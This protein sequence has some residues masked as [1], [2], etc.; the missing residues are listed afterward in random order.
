MNSTAKDSELPAADSCAIMEGED[1]EDDLIFTSKKSLFGKIK[2]FTYKVGAHPLCRCWG[3]QLSPAPQIRGEPLNPLALTVR[4]GRNAA[5]VLMEWQR[6]RWSCGYV[7]LESGLLGSFP[8]LDAGHL[9]ATSTSGPH[10]PNPVCQQ[11]FGGTANV[12]KSPSLPTAFT[13]LTHTPCMPVPRAAVSK[14]LEDR[15]GLVF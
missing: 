4:M 10:F 7:V 11:G 5:G 15:Q 14:E 12:P 2:S 6:G 3:Q 9:Q 13:D 8:S 1:V